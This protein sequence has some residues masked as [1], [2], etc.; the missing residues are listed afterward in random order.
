MGGKPFYICVGAERLATLKTETGT[1]VDNPTSERSRLSRTSCGT[2]GGEDKTE[3]RRR[4]EKRRGEE[5]SEEK[6][7]GEEGKRTA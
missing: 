7:R 1:S 2:Q 5:G 6:L 4:W 3:E